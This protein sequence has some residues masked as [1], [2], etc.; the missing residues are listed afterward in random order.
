LLLFV[1]WVKNRMA[2]N[3]TKKKLRLIH[4]EDDENDRELV[5]R[6]LLRSLIDAEITYAASEPDL[7]RVLEAQHVDVILADYKLPGFSGVA[8]LHIA[9]ELHPDVPFVFLSGTMDDQQAIETF[10]LGASDY[11]FKDHLNRLAGAI[12]RALRESR[13]IAEL[14]RAEESLRGSEERFRQLTENIEEVFWLIDL[15]EHKFLY[16]SPAYEKIWGRTCQSLYDDA[17]S[18]RDSLHSEDR[19]AVVASFDSAHKGNCDREFRIIRPDGQVRWVNSRAFPIFD[20]SGIAYRVAGVTTDI[21]DRKRLESQFLRAQRMESIGTLA[22]GIAH[23]LNNA[24]SPVVMSIDLLRERFQDQD[25]QMLLDAVATSAE[26]GAQMVK[27]LLTFARGI[28]G[29]H[30][31]IQVKHII[32]EVENILRQTLPK[33]IRIRAELPKKDLWTVSGDA[34]QLHQVLL[35]LCVNARDAMPH[36]GTLTIKACNFQVDENIANTCVDAKAGRYVLLSVCDTGIGI[37]PQIRERIFDPFFTTKPLD[38]GTGL[39]LSTVRGIVQ[40]HCGF[41][42]VYSEVGRGSEFKVFLPAQDGPAPT[43]VNDKAADVPAGK[44][45]LI[46][47]VDDE[48]SIRIMT[49]RTLEAFHY[50]V[51]TAKN[52]ADAIAVCAR[53]MQNI[54]IIITDIAM[55]VIDGV[56][57][58]ATVRK[59]APK[60]KVIA[61]SGLDKVPDVSHEHAFGADHF[62]SKPFTAE[63][64]LRTVRNLI[65]R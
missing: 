9:K 31:A 25:S 34:T 60:V 65:D 17:H 12:E 48:E 10:K 5:L 13:Q 63:V 28:E 32:R 15:T 49:Q 1:T 20:A 53:E 40:S 46:L 45:E 41:I 61:A 38:K 47:V 26:R 16:V 27:Q 3:E 24:L 62:L 14:R 64:L 7:R 4:V 8:A 44:G 36:G 35:N 30:V 56:G 18:W 55:P 23:D 58:I 37:P 39:G 29:K 21:S 19:D 42:S 22:G 59:L 51:L 54:Q 52:G 11:V 2:G 57:L 33:N 6:Q 43:L 50:K